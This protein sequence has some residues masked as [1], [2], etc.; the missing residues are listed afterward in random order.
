MAARHT[1]ELFSDRFEIATLVL[2]SIAEDSENLDEMIYLSN[3]ILCF[4]T[5]EV[6]RI[7]LSQL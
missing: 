7:G 2:K 6:F 3:R 4:E 5:V 1:V